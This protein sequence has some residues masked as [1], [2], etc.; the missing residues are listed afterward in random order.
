MKN[1]NGF[2]LIES[3]VAASLLMMV[4]TTVIPLTSLLLHE[5]ETLQQKQNISGELHHQ[6]QTFLREEQTN[7]PHRLLKTIDGTEAEFRFIA[8][9]NLVKGCATW[10]NANERE[11]QFCLYG[12]QQR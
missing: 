4:I 3:L 1:S 7:L 9:S 6:L 12:Y 2:S 5:R 11:S 8:E 10:K